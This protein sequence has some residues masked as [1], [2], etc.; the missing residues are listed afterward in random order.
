MPFIASGDTI[1]IHYTTL[2]LE[3]SVIESSHNREPLQFRVGSDE[4][5]KNRAFFV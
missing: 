1:R 3:G 5:F 4:L 2:S